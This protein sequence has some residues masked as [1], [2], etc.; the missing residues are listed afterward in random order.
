M[1]RGNGGGRKKGKEK[2]AWREERRQGGGK[3]G[4]QSGME[5]EREG[6]IA[7]EIKKVYLC[8]VRCNDFDMEDKDEIFIERINAKE[9]RAFHELFQRF[10]NY[11]VVFAIRRVK[12][13][14]VAEDVV[15]EVI[16]GVWMSDKPFNSFVGFK[17]WLYNAVANRCTDYLKHEEVERRHA[18]E[19]QREGEPTDEWDVVEEEMY[20]ELHLAVGE[21][22]ER[23]RRVF[24][25]HLDGKRN[26][27]IARILQ[28][29]LLT[30]K[31][32]KRDAMQY[33]KKRLGDAYFFLLA[34]AFL[35]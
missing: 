35:G 27:E 26:E 29:T 8:G 24:E 31:S 13:Q 17:T 20:R 33:L 9:E 5:A 10:Y 21:L 32:Y 14:D 15:M 16:E 6:A 3:G 2:R 30:V 25:L 4:R 34:I 12:R 19:V 1:E 11:L 22:P 7:R 23:V 18:A 28:L